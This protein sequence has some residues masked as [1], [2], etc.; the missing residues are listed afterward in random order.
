MPNRI[1][2][3]LQNLGELTI[4]ERI[5]VLDSTAKIRTFVVQNVEPSTM[6]PSGVQ[7]PYVSVDSSLTDSQIISI[8]A[9]P[10]SIQ[11]SSDLSDYSSARGSF[12]NLPSWATWSSQDAVNYI[13][14]N[15]LNGMTQAQ[16]DSYINANA[17]SISGIN[18]VLHQVGTAL[19]NIRTIL[20]AVAQGIIFIRNL[21]IRF[22]R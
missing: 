9:S 10:T 15:I 8:L 2:D 5:L 3:N 7:T 6:I 21:I 19:I 16:V 11:E 17:T 20:S 18:T 12:L 4:Y 22:G 13:T 14:Q 1:F